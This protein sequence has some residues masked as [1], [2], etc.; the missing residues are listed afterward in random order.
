MLSNYLN[1]AGESKDRLDLLIALADKKI[2]E[3]KIEKEKDTLGVSYSKMLMTYADSSDK[4]LMGIGYF[5]AIATGM[6]MPSFV[7]LF[8]NI[9]NSFGGDAIEAIEK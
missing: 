5:M 4:W 8:G 2:E 3:R 7:F 6:A 9:T 1:V